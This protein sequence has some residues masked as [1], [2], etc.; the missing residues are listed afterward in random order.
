MAQGSG[1]IVSPEGV[2]ATNYHVIE[3]AHEVYIRLTNGKIIRTQL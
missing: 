1:F 3:S 2:V